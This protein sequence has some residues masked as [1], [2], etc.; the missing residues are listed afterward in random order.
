MAQVVP[1]TALNVTTAEHILKSLKRS[2]PDASGTPGAI[3]INDSSQHLDD[4][5]M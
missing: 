3:W 4:V 2:V 1:S 5:A